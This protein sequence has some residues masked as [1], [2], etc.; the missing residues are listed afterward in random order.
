[1]LALPLPL[2]PLLL[3][4]SLPLFFPVMKDFILNYDPVAFVRE[5]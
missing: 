4:L 2:P 5:K 3:P 1:M